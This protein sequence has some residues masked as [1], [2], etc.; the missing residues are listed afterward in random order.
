MATLKPSVDSSSAQSLLNQML[1]D[2]HVNAEDQ[3]THKSMF[4]F[5]HL[6][7]VLSSYV[8][9][10]NEL[11]QEEK[12][13]IIRSCIIQLK[14]TKKQNAE[15]LLRAIELSV[16]SLLQVSPKK[17][18]MTSTISLRRVSIKPPIKIRIA[19]VDLEIG[20][21]YPSKIKSASWFYNGF[22]DVQP[23][24][25]HH[26][27][28]LCASTKAK[29]AL[30][31]AQTMINAFDLLTAILNFLNQR[32][33]IK[34]FGGR[35]RPYNDIRLGEFQVIHND[36]GNILQDFLWYDPEFYGSTLA[37]ELP[38]PDR[39]RKIVGL[40]NRLER[41]VFRELLRAAL[42]Q[43]N[44]AF[45]IRD[46]HSSLM[47]LWSALEL[48]TGTTK[49]ESRV[50]VKRA[51]FLLPDREYFRLI[52]DYASTARNA[53]AHLGV[54]QHQIDDLINAVKLVVERLIDKLLYF[55]WKVDGPEMLF[56]LMDMPTKPDEL[57][58]ALRVAKVSSA[59]HKQQIA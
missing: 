34:I 49:L 30:Q 43:Y 13:K 22:G 56:R 8:A 9:V 38:E 52:L 2:L 16:S 5:D 33:S 26:Y 31:A 44:G 21:R 36:T 17:Y 20:G 25:P 19:G 7:P 51:L 10:S 53:Y 40:S 42:L 46:R 45:G 27:A 48:L 47:K 1:S 11:T 54:Q 24:T 39:I 28:R 4:R 3:I 37:A 18:Y 29:T 14:R 59:I 15:E 50:T 6:L 58:R 35:L 57:I 12:D 55:Q 41:S 23:A 32:G